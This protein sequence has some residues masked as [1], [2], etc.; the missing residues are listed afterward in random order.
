MSVP[1]FVFLYLLGDPGC[2][3]T[4]RLAINVLSQS[5]GDAPELMIEVDAYLVPLDSI[6]EIGNRLKMT[7][8]YDQ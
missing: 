7:L 1:P 4:L 3:Q 2:H 8:P 6:Y 5:L